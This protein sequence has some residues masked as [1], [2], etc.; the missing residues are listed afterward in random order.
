MFDGKP[1]PE[2]VIGTAID[3]ML[4]TR[5]RKIAGYGSGRMKER[6]AVLAPIRQVARG[7]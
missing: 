6:R 5:D 3:A 4:E 1:S 2:R 7:K